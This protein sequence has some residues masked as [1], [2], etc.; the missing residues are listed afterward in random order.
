ML[1]SHSKF[2]NSSSFGSFAAAPR[3]SSVIGKAQSPT[4]VVPPQPIEGS[5]IVMD[6]SAR[7]LSDM[8]TYKARG[9]F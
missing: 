1:P 5:F 4:K 8:G 9:K 7:K 2:T 6:D 3:S